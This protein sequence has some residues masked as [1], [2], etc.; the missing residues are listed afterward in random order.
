MP[1]KNSRKPYSA[2]GYY[3]IYNRGVEKRKIFLDQQ[4][5]GV[6]LGYLKEYLLPKNEKELFSNL[7]DPHLSPGDKDKILKAI[8]LNNYF[9]DI[10]LIA[11]CLMPNH[12]HLLLHQNSENAIDY[13]MNSFGSRFTGYFNRKYKRVGTL[14]Q[15]VYKAVL[16]LSE[17][18]LLHLTRYIHRNPLSLA[19]QDEVLQGIARGKKTDMTRY[20]VRQPSSYPEYVGLRKTDWVHPEEI[21]NYFSKT[22]P[23]LSYKSFVMGQDEVEIIKDVAIDM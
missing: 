3:H 4:D 18:Q 9:G 8:R 5:Y 17:E 1:A 16:I 23:R 15:D 21:L 10:S 20:F 14:Y 6:F 12:Y 22:N 13:F 11:Y 19:P 2:N 7:A